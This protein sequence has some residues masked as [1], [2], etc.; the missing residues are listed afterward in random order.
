MTLERDKAKADRFERWFEEDGLKDA[1]KDIKE[2]YVKGLV[3]SHYKDKKA[4]ENC[5]VALNVLERI[6]GHILNV[7]G[8]GKMADKTLKAIE[9]ESKNKKVFKLF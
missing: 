3:N 7:I 5:Y 4:R 8:G 1:L 6:E 9:Q 2:A